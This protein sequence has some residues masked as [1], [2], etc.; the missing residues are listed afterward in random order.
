MWPAALTCV[1]T[2]EGIICLGG[3]RI[4]VC[5]LMGSGVVGEAVEVG[6]LEVCMIVVT[7]GSSRF[8]C[9]GTR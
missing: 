9:M 6:G 5:E 8:L 1:V 7:G 4:H 3:E 2:V